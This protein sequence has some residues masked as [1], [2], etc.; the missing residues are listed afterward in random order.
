M[1]P[2]MH[3]TENRFTQEDP[4]R[5]FRIMAEFV[6]S[7]ETLSKVGPAVTVFGSARTKPDDVYYQAS[8]ALAKKLAKNDLA[9]ITG[10]GPGIMAAANRG[11]AEAKGKSVGLN[12]ELPMEQSANRYSNVP[13]HFHYFFARKVCFVKYSVAFVFMPGGFGTLDEFFEVATL[14]QTGRIP[15]FPLILFG[16]DY[17][18]GLLE[19]CKKT[20]QHRELIGATDLKLVSVTDD[21][22][23]A[24]RIVLD[25]LRR[26]GPPQTLPKAF[27]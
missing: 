10:G 2:A 12:I 1:V 9:V 3:E 21:P 27:M 6:D 14:V 22:D 7:F 23:E 5:I 18:S 20:L 17:W 25:Y 11:A 19:W 15:Q 4:W 24:V 26:V 13:V 16:R 8:V